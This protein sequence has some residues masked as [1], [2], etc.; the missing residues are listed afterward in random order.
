MLEVEYTDS[1]AVFPLNCP[2]WG[3]DWSGPSLERRE[4]TH[5]QR[6]HYKGVA[7]RWKSRTRA[8]FPHRTMADKCQANTISINYSALSSQINGYLWVENVFS[9]AR[10]KDGRRLMIFTTQN[11]ER[12]HWLW[13]E[14]DVAWQSSALRVIAK[15][16][17]LKLQPRNNAKYNANDFN[18][19]CCKRR[20]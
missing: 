9:E 2:I 6:L 18:S 15:G 3:D 10:D 4:E 19:H 5:T 11:M 7:M 8:N 16:Y 12:P 1:N 14:S 13:I 17:A 20:L